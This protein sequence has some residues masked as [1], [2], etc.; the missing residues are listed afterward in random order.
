MQSGDSPHLISFPWQGRCCLVKGPNTLGFHSKSK[1]VW[2]LLGRPSPT[3]T[4]G[5]KG[6]R[7]GKE[8][9]A[10]ITPRRDHTSKTTLNDNPSESP[11]SKKPWLSNGMPGTPRP[12]EG[13]TT[14]RRLALTWAPVSRSPRGSPTS[15]PLP[16]RAEQ[17][18]GLRAPRL[19]GSVYLG[20]PN[21]HHEHHA[22]GQIL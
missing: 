13:Q 20:H 10:G 11:T 18:A 4:Q 8:T 19:R 2:T 17:G 3:L 9:T 1:E 21:P 22:L 7:N 16:D 5:E 6:R 14:G 12:V 15:R